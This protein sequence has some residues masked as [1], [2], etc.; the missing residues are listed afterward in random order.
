MFRPCEGSAASTCST[1]W[2]LIVQ[3]RQAEVKIIFFGFFAKQA[4]RAKPRHW[5]E[6]LFCVCELNY[7]LHPL[8]FRSVVL[9][10]AWVWSARQLSTCALER[11]T[12]G[13]HA[14]F[15]GELSM[16]QTPS[17]FWKIASF[18]RQGRLHDAT[19]QP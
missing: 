10:R 1:S 6:L 14:P 12:P 15:V 3:R 11:T 18:A 13:R 4:T 2:L 8:Q 5:R 7:Q 19:E 16:R 17:T 9:L